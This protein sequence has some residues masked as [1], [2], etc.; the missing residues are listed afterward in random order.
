ME[1]KGS[2]LNN[3]TALLSHL[4]SSPKRERQYFILS[5]TSGD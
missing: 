3:E 4:S 2:W 1:D 5:F